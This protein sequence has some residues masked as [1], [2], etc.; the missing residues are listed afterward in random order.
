MGGERLPVERTGIAQTGGGGGLPSTGGTGLVVQTGPTTTVARTL[1][2]GPGIDISNGN[3]VAGNPVIGITPVFVNATFLYPIYLTTN[4]LGQ[5]VGCGTT[6]YPSSVIELAQFGIPFFGNA[7]GPAE[8][9]GR[10]TGPSSTPVGVDAG[11]FI[12][13][14]DKARIDKFLIKTALPYPPGVDYQVEIWQIDQFGNETQA[15]SDTTGLPIVI[16]V[17]AG[18]TVG[19]NTTDVYTIVPGITLLVKSDP[20]VGWNPSAAQ[21]VARRTKAV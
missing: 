11:G 12:E 3:G 19:Q 5:V 18:S 21:V 16:P 14:D 1:T 9:I 17:P 6:E 15:I 20:S 7:W 2:P 13:C 4:Q 10:C 8:Y